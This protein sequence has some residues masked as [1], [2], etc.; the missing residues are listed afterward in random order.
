MT[1][2]GAFG[3]DRGGRCALPATPDGGAVWLEV[4]EASLAGDASATSGQGPELSAAGSDRRLNGGGER[5][6]ESATDRRGVEDVQDGVSPAS[7]SSRVRVV[8][9]CLVL[10]PGGDVGELPGIALGQA[11]DGG[12]LA[13]G[14]SEEHQLAGVDA[15]IGGG[16]LGDLTAIGGD[17]AGV[18]ADVEV[19][20]PPLLRRSYAARSAP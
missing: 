3:S 4:S 16:G 6:S 5:L 12:C 20:V 7:E 8:R 2:F 10:D 17:V 1:A 15:L 14:S 11:Q 13:E 19:V 9:R 18:G